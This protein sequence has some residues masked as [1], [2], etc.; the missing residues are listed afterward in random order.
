MNYLNNGCALPAVDLRPVQYNIVPATWVNSFGSW[1][2]SWV[3]E[4]NNVPASCT[5]NFP[6]RP[7]CAQRPIDEWLH[8]CA[9]AMFNILKINTACTGPCKSYKGKLIWK[10]QMSYC[11]YHRCR[12]ATLSFRDHMRSGRACRSAHAWIRTRTQICIENL[13]VDTHSH[14]GTRKNQHTDIEQFRLSSWLWI[15]F[16]VLLVGMSPNTCSGACA[17]HVPTLARTRNLS[18]VI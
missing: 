3:T 6:A 18:H 9:R 7:R 12:I 4:R 10:K 2:C 14:K 13:Q 11:Y 8:V 17:M 16:F 15:L 5:A 1:T